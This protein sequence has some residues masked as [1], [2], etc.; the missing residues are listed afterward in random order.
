M[1]RKKKP[2]L[3]QRQLKNQNLRK[4]KKRKR[5]RKKKRVTLFLQ[6]LWEPCLKEETCQLSTMQVQLLVLKVTDFLKNQQLDR[7]HKPEEKNRRYQFQHIAKAKENLNLTI[8]VCTLVEQW[9]LH[10]EVRASMPDLM[11]I[12]L[13][14]G[15]R[16]NSKTIKMRHQF[17]D[18]YQNKLDQ[19]L[20]FKHLKQSPLIGTWI[21][22][23]LSHLHQKQHQ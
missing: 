16:F 19:Q 23:I 17:Q 11:T 8:R 13:T 14:N 10:Q 18:R 15:L 20:L 12:K 5:K 9:L 7:L 6:N 3:K 22:Y 2:R 1:K 4:K 21:N